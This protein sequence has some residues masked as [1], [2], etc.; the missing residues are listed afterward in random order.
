MGRPRKVALLPAG[1]LL[2]SCSQG[3]EL[4]T[5]GSLL[6]STALPTRGVPCSELD[7]AAVGESGGRKVASSQLRRG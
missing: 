3:G 6:L 1:A 4:C 2:A 7:E 5:P